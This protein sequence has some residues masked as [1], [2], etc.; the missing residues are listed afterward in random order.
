MR[1][2]RSAAS[3]RLWGKH[4]EILVDK[5]WKSIGRSVEKVGEE[6]GKRKN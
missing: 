5:V 1:L 3:Y 4:V 2:S 6:K